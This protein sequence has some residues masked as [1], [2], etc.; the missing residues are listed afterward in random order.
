VHQRQGEDAFGVYRP[1]VCILYIYIY[2]YI[3]SLHQ[4][5]HQRQGEPPRFT[6]PRFGSSCISIY[7]YIHLYIPHAFPSFHLSRF[8]L[9]KRGVRWSRDPTG[10]SASLPSILMYPDT[11]SCDHVP[12]HTLKYSDTRLCTQTHA[13]VIMY[14]DTRSCD[15][16]PR[17]PG[18]SHTPMCPRQE[19]T[20][21]SAAGRHPTSASTSLQARPSRPA[22]GERRFGLIRG[23]SC[24]I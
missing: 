24:Q 17:Q 1:T 22:L 23:L 3:Y 16:V 15:H 14:P 18:L 11:R 7:L 2:I 13:H 5:L 6:G 9:S 21:A 12:R 4:S 20:E 10:S 19:L 8:H